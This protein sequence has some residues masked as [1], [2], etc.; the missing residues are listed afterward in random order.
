MH[1]PKSGERWGEKNHADAYTDTGFQKD[2]P[3]KQY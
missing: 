2:T 1:K 3:K